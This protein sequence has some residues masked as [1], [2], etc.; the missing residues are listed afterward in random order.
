MPHDNIENLLWLMIDILIVFI[1]QHNYGEIIL[2]KT[3]ETGIVPMPPTIVIDDFHPVRVVEHTPREAVVFD[4]WFFEAVRGIGFFQSG[5]FDEL[6]R[7]KCLIPFVQVFDCAVYAF[8][9]RHAIKMHL[10]L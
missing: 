5:R 4:A 7:I 2:D 3:I 6:T 9:A 1:T 8:V 10:W